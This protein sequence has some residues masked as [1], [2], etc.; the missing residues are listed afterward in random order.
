MRNDNKLLYI[1]IAAIGAFAFLVGRGRKGSS[2]IPSAGGCI[3][4][5]SSPD[6]DSWASDLKAMFQNTWFWTAADYDAAIAILNNLPDQC[7]ARKFYDFF[8][9][10]TTFMYGSGDLD[11]WL[12]SW[13]ENWKIKAR[14][15][16]HGVGSF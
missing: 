7:A 6:I 1:A 13:P 3:S 15:Y 12:S 11:Y 8:G 2:V 16:L 5:A 9:V 10:V 4:S 14:T